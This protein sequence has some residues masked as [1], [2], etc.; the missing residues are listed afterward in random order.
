LAPI[1]NISLYVPGGPQWACCEGGIANDTVRNT[2]PSPGLSLLKR[3]LAIIIADRADGHSL[4]KQG[5]ISPIARLKRHN[6][7]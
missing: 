1:N 2:K 6:S 5:M 7:W 4:S 3:S